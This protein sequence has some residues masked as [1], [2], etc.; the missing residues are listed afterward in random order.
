V[1]KK[2]PN[3]SPADV[4]NVQK[5]QA[6]GV[7]GK[8]QAALLGRTY[9]QWRTGVRHYRLE[10]KKKIP[11]TTEELDKVRRWQ[12]ERVPGK[13]QATMLGRTYLAWRTAVEYH[14]LGKRTEYWT[15]KQVSQVQQWQE[16]GVPGKEQ[17]RRL[18]KSY[19]A[20]KSGVTRYKL[21]G[22]HHDGYNAEIRATIMA[23]L[24]IGYTQAD[25]VRMTGRKCHASIGKIT[26]ELIGKGL[27]VKVG[28]NGRRW[29][30][31]AT[32]KWHGKRV[33]RNRKR[34]TQAGAKGDRQPAE[35]PVLDG[36]SDTAATRG[37]RTLSILP[38][39][40]T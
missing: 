10:V 37:G 33:E 17:A 40:M 29:T 3:W 36:R 14:R 9:S 31:A 13:E 11:W 30:Y 32:E 23:Y 22:E 18:G 25:I 27:L 28:R 19:F 21:C 12:A 39:E 5:W 34:S 15:Q 1:A 16:Q 2:N 20:W 26:R 4:S 24:P 7:P 35:P 38:T 6:A 8:Q